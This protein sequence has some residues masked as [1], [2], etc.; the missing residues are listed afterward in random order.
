MR[1]RKLRKYGPVLAAL[2]AMTSAVTMVPRTA[3]AAAGAGA[4]GVTDFQSAAADP[5]I[6]GRLYSA[7]S[8]FNQAIPANPQLDPKSAEYVKLMNRSKKEKGFVLALDEWTVPAYFAKPATKRSDVRIIGFDEVRRVMRGVPIPDNARP[9]PADDGHLTVIDPATRCEYDLYDAEKTATGW[10]AKWANVTSTSDTGIYPYGLSSRATGFAPLAGMIW[11]SEL[12][13][14]RIDHAL[15]FAYP[16]TRA[17]GPVAPATSSDGTTTLAAAMPEGARV[18]LDPKLNLGSLGL[19]AHERT[20]AEALQR[21]G[22]FLGDTGGALSLYGVHPQSFDTDQY[23]GLVPDDPYT[24][25]NKI[26]VDRFRVLKT[27][28]QVAQ[29]RYSIVPSTCARIDVV[30]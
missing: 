26:P 7:T 5:R 14:G 19:S 9:D 20:I 22:M 8:P 12:R 3:D 6:G 24:F 28:K 2:L 27:G 23:A 30:N 25:L 29:T 21:Y 11:P 13:N 18:Q 4:A 10:T 17:G 1:R 15:V 16:Y